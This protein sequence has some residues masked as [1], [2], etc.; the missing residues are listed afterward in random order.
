MVL[1]LR[2]LD[3]AAAREAC[4]DP[5]GPRVLAFSTLFPNPAQP[6]LG[7]FVRDR[8]AAVAAHCPTRVVAPVLS[9]LGLQRL[10]HGRAGSIPVFEHQAGL[11]VYHPPFN[12]IPRVG[13]CVDGAL[14]FLQTIGLVRRLWADWQFDVIDAHY[15]FPDGAAA[16]H[17][18]RLLRV[19]VCITVRGGD[20]DL[21]PRFRLRRRAIRHALRNAQR[22]F[23]VSEHLAQRAATLGAPPDR[24]Q[25]VGNGI[26]PRKF[27]PSDRCVARKVVG[28]SEE[29]RLVLCVAHLIA[30]K[31]QHVLIEAFARLGECGGHQPHLVVIGSDQRGNQDY[32]KRL[33][34]QIAALGLGERVHL[35][36]AKPQEE[37]RAWYTAA[38]VVVLPTFR[39]G[40]PNVVRE[41]LACGAPVVASRVGG[42]PELLTSESFGLL[43]TPGDSAGLAHAIAAAL[44]R[45]WDRDAIA[46]GREARTWQAVARTLAHELRSVV[47]EAELRGLS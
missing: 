30:E 14:L 46:A 11:D 8:V 34:R 18:G 24:I 19:P 32:R 17:L 29:T 43:V 4:A 35:F 27:Y 16:V 5:A 7:V 12:T 39:E 33:E 13:R 44:Q 23:A 1:Q 2:T 6:R 26:D 31:G 47:R 42:V 25:V 22:V 37:L 20:M 3:V 28:F 9:R 38:D 36:P 40:C 10:E 45:R 41:A 21:L 15:A